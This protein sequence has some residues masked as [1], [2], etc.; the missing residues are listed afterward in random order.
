[1]KVLK[2]RTT[3]ILVLDQLKLP[4]GNSWNRGSNV[5]KVVIRLFGLCLTDFNEKPGHI[6][7]RCHKGNFGV[8][9]TE[10][11][12]LEVICLSSH[13]RNNIKS[14]DNDIYHQAW[15]SRDLSLGLETEL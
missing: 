8:Y 1:M 7:H 11:H 6:H 4:F 13:L 9:E 5:L 10:G 3:H 2:D 15:S 12:Y 14:A